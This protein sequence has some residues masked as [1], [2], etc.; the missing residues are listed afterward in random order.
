LCS[1]SLG[2]PGY[3]RDIERAMGREES[4]VEKRRTATARR[5]VGA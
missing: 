1:A 3:L 4:T 2:D 5:A